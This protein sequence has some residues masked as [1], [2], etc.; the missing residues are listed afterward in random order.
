MLLLVSGATK[1]LTKFAG[2]PHIGQLMTP[3]SGNKYREDMPVGV[4]NCAYSDWDEQK[5]IRMIDSLAGKKVLWVAAPDFLGDARVTS[6]LYDKW[7]QEIKVKRNLPIAY[8]LQDGLDEIGAPYYPYDAVFIGG[9][10]EFKLGGYVRYFVNAAKQHG[11]LIHMGRVNSFER[12][13][14]AIDIG[15]DS[16]DGSGFSI[17]PDRKIAVFLKMIEQYKQNQDIFGGLNE[18][19]M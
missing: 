17:E 6:V 2:N 4:D 18:T 14:Y 7:Y 13:K 15:C 9:T 5:F 8:V 10:T 1:T 19:A 3:Q 11:K 12:M 16:V